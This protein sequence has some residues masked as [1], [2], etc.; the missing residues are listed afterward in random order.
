MAEGS[1]ADAQPPAQQPSEA[2]DAAI[3]A[4]ITAFAD[5]DLGVAMA[6]FVSAHALSPSARTLRGMGMVAF[7]QR[8][9]RRAYG[10]LQAALTDPRRALGAAHRSHVT[11]L[12]ARSR[13]FLGVYRLTL[14]PE[15]ATLTDNGEP[16]T[17][18]GTGELWLPLGRHVIRASADGHVTQQVELEVVGNE[19]QPLSIHLVPGQDPETAAV[20]LEQPVSQPAARDAAAEPTEPTEPDDESA[21]TTE[22]SDA[23]LPH[24]P[25]ALVL[26]GG[27]LVAGSVVTA[28]LQRGMQSD[29]DDLCG[30]QRVC[31]AADETEARELQSDGE[32][33]AL[34]TDI[35][36]FTGVAVAATGAFLWVFDDGAESDRAPV[37]AAAVCL[38]S[39]CSVSTRVAF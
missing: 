21:T 8:R 7:E 35:F 31:V 33:L 23:D 26:V 4:A 20:P 12:L 24:L 5:K 1:S 16:I 9:F 15:G 37:S 34:M 17:A 25:I 29:L 18:S 38:P 22:L 39:G 19:E 28:I 36:L 13:S 27:G 2:Y 10:H 14:A 30:E 32:T 3:R 11:D 6:Q